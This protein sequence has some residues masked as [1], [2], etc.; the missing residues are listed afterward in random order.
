METEK[1]KHSGI[2]SAD[3]IV[4]QLL[5]QFQDS[6]ISQSNPYRPQQTNECITHT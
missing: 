4:N 6:F 3:Q 2:A 1:L 5:E